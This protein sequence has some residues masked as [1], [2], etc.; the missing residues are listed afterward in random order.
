MTNPMLKTIGLLAGT[1]SIALCPAAAMA[2]PISDEQ[3]AALLS[4]LNQLEREVADL[5]AQLGNVQQTQQASTS[6]IAATEAKLAATEEKLEQ[7][8]KL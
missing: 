1:A 2:A 8:K 5:K 7:Q 4:K 6:A 3:A